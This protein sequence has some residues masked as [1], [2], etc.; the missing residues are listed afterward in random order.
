L[1][2]ASSGGY[3]NSASNYPLVQLRRLDNEQTVWLTTAAFSTTSFTTMAVTGVAPG[4]AQIT[5]FVNGIPS[6]SRI[7]LVVNPYSIYLPMAIKN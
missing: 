2:E 5:A 6:A 3:H 7:V 1:S 4:Y